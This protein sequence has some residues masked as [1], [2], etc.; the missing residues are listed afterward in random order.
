MAT[1]Q[2][3]I[4]EIN[5]LRALRDQHQRTANRFADQLDRALERLAKHLEE[6]KE[7]KV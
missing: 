3:L 5:R 2:T 4:N 1:K 6:T 7:A